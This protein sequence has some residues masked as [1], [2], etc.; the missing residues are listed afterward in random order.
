[1]LFNRKIRPQGTMKTFTAFCLGFLTHSG[2][3]CSKSKRGS[4]TLLKKGKIFKVGGYI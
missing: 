2:R 3:N 1:M 4:L